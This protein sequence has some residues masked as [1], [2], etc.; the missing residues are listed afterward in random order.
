[1]TSSRTVTPTYTASATPTST[2]TITATFSISPT[3]SPS[4]TIT[5]TFSISPTFS[6]TKTPVDQS[7]E[8]QIRGVYPNPFSEQV[9]AIL[10]LK[11]DA[12]VDIGVYNVAGEPVYNEKIPKLAGVNIWDW[13]GINNAGA[14][15]ASG[16]YVIRASCPD[17]GGQAS[18]LVVAIAR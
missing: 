18:Y 13:N 6:I 16:V 7:G 1:L 5:P 11:D 3:Y 10:V 2:K 9:H 8:V 14:R 12:T 15:L 17:W 4:P